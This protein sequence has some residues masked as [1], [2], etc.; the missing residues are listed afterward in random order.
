[1]CVWWCTCIDTHWV[2]YAFA[3][4]GLVA[5]HNGELIHKQQ[6]TDYLDEER[7]QRLLNF[8]LRYIADLSIPVKRY[9]FIMQSIVQHI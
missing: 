9:H 1:M 6:L 3:E 4:N 8:I 5:Y 2:D 7:L